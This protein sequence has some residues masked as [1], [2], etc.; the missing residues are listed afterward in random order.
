VIWITLYLYMCILLLKCVL[1]MPA[2]KVFVLY[3]DICQMRKNTFS[4][5]FFSSLFFL[6]KDSNSNPGESLFTNFVYQLKMWSVSSTYLHSFISG[7]GVH[8]PTDKTLNQVKYLSWS[9]FFLMILNVFLLLELETQVMRRLKI[10]WLVRCYIGA[11]REFPAQ[12]QAP[13]LSRAAHANMIQ[14]NVFEVGESTLLNIIISSVSIIIIITCVFCFQKCEFKKLSYLI[15]YIWD[16]ERY[17]NINILYNNTLKP[18]TD[19]D[20][21]K[22]KCKNYRTILYI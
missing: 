20:R 15:L 6:V 3:I 21:T 13:T 18:D 9:L 11:W 5:R 19:C 8:L 2:Y 17:R 14:C 10:V 16:K 4:R 12:Q 1:H 22:S 7:R